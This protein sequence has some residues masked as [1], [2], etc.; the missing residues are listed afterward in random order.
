MGTESHGRRRL[1]NLLRQISE[2]RD[3]IQGLSEAL[4]PLL[5]SNLQRLAESN[6]QCP[7]SSERPPREQGEQSPG[8]EDPRLRDSSGRS[9]QHM[10]GGTQ[11]HS[12]ESVTHN[13][14]DDLGSTNTGNTALL[15]CNAA[16][17]QWQCSLPYY[18]KCSPSISSLPR[19]GQCS[20][21][22]TRQCSQLSCG[23]CSP[24]PQRQCSHQYRTM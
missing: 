8:S 7:G 22:F 1:L 21:D 11:H 24:F 10:D 12:G 15:S 18:G 14:Q 9:S 2:N 4:M 13:I 5:V 19:H 3:V 16:Y 20:P 23:Q 17:R 6:R